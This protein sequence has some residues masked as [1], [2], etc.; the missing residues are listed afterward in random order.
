MKSMKRILCILSLLALCAAQMAYAQD[1]AA[2]PVPVAFDRLPTLVV[3]GSPDYQKDLQE[4][5]KTEISINEIQSQLDDLHQNWNANLQT[6]MALQ[7]NLWDAEDYLEELN[8]ALENKAKQRLYP[9]QRLYMNHYVLT[10]DVE[11]AQRE[12]AALEN[13]LSTCRQKRARGLVTQS[14]VDAVEKNVKAQRDKAKAAQTKVDDNLEAMAK[15]LSMDDIVLEALP[16]MDFKRI[17]DRDLKADLAAYIP[18][19]SAS[20]E[21]AMRAAR[22]KS[23]DS[24]A[25]RYAYT[26]AERDYQQAKKDAEKAFPK[27]YETLKDA[28]DDMLESTALADAQKEYDRDKVRFDRGLI[29]RNQLLGS[30]RALAN[31]RSLAKQREIQVWLLFMEYEYSLIKF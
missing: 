19:A 22:R 30:E 23:D 11:T 2:G 21:K 24:R 1:E 15:T 3:A 9:V 14:A 7:A 12:L 10:F 6:I 4:I 5:R 25:D 13:D 31:A 29:A 17:A 28:Y 26:M 27:V 8:D 16:A 18:A 20:A